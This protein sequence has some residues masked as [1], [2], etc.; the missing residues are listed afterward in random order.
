MKQ[1]IEEIRKVNPELAA[2]FAG[3]EREHSRLVFARTLAVLAVICL[4]VVVFVSNNA[5]DTIRQNQVDAC[6]TSLQPGGIRYIV[7]SQ[8]QEQIRQ[9]K[10]LDYA[11][12]FPNVPAD[13][14]HQLIA[15]QNAHRTQQVHDLLDVNC[16]A[17]YSK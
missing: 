11:R 7:S 10:Q 2:V 4:V 3:I 1:A 16:D 12:F 8:I 17:L 15:T 9:S 5:A 13:E 6:K 14:L